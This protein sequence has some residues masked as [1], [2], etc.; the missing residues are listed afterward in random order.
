MNQIARLSGLRRF[1]PGEEA[2][3]ELVN[4][5]VAVCPSEQGAERLVSEILE[6]CDECPTPAGLRHWARRRY[7]AEAAASASRSAA[8]C[9]SCDGVGWVIVRKLV[10]V[11]GVGEYPATGADPCPKCNPITGR[12]GRP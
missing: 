12:G 3:R 5:L 7:T 9:R 10:H 1:P 11:A 4:A 2:R 6:D 8:G